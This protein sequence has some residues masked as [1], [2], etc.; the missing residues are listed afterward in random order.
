M[1]QQQQ[2]LPENLYV[3]LWS[4][5]LCENFENLYVFSYFQEKKKNGRINQKQI[6]IVTYEVGEIGNEERRQKL[7]LSD[8]CLCTVLTWELCTYFI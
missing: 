7:D 1:K 8:W 2:N 5:F 3:F 6:Q 4:I